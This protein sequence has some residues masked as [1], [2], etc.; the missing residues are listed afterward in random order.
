MAEIAL[1]A[2]V[3]GG[4]LSAAQ[5]HNQGQI[6]SRNAT[7]TANQLDQN[8]KAYDVAANNAQGVS[9][10]KANEQLRQNRLV[11][12]RIIALNAAGGGSS[13]EKNVSDL[14]ARTAGQGEYAALG[15]LF[16]GD[17]RATQLRNQG[18]G[19]QNQALVTR[20]EGRNARTAGNIATVTG[21][22]GTGA[23]AGSF[24]SKYGTKSPLDNGTQAGTAYGTTNYNGMAGY[25]NLEPNTTLNFNSNF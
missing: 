9:Q 25:N 3:A 22:L 11:Q 2:M 6:A 16:E 20:A 5:A 14:L 12:S 23:T 7:I 10:Q 4:V 18:I 21:L 1:T 19:L 8:A 15:T 24:Y 13:N 17:N